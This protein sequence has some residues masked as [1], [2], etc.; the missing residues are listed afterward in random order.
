M[1]S[2]VVVISLEIVVKR[3]QNGN[4]TSLRVSEERKSL[5]GGVFQI[6]EAD[7]IAELLDAIQYSVCATI[8]L[9]QSVISQVLVYPQRVQRCGVKTRKE[10]VHDQ[11]Q[12]YLSVLHS[13]RNILIV[14]GELV[15]TGVVART[16]HL[17]IVLDGTL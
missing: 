9:Q 4:T 13:Q 14:V 12:V 10:H 5:V 6:A 11:Q 17:V 1:L 16:K 8:R 15:G 7:N 3:A 2:L